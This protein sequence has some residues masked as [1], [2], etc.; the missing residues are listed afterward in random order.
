MKLVP[1]ILFSVAVAFTYASA[2]NDPRSA[3]FADL[4]RAQVKYRASQSEVIRKADR[5]VVYLVDFEI[6]TSDDPFGN[7]LA[8]DDD[9][10]RVSPSGGVAKILTT[11]EVPQDHKVKILDTLATQIAKPEHDGGAMCHFPIHGI[12]VYRGEELL[13][14][15]TL[16][17]VCGNFSFSYPEGS[18]W[19]DTSKELEKIFTILL[20]IPPKELDRFYQKYPGAKPKGEQGGAANPA[21]PGG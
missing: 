7:S 19:L 14:E 12:R 17:W 20:P 1:F 21:K 2:E 6:T 10:I 8:G 15:G 3:F 5:V 9:A 4:E 18:G 11:K 13:H 16:C